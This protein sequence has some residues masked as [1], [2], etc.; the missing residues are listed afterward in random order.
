V[1]LII[2]LDA[3]PRYTTQVSS[4]TCASTTAQNKETSIATVK[5]SMA[6]TF[7]ETANTSAHLTTVNM[8]SRGDVEASEDDWITPNDISRYTPQERMRQYYEEL[9]LQRQCEWYE[10]SW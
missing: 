4:A 6:S 7:M 10:G 3:M 5:L 9:N 1:I 8:V 2:D